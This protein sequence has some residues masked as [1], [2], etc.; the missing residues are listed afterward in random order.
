MRNPYTIKALV[1][2]G[3]VSKSFPETNTLVEC[4]LTKHLELAV[5]TNF[6]ATYH[7]PASAAQHYGMYANRPDFPMCDGV[8][9]THVWIQGPRGGIYNIETGKRSK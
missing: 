5:A 3:K 6:A 4:T 2:V 8:R 1:P 9:A 7:T